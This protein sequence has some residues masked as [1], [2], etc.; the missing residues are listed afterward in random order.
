MVINKTPKQKKPNYF[1]TTE[2]AMTLWHYSA[3][4]GSKWQILIGLCLFRGLRVGE[5]VA[6]NIKD[7]KD[8]NFNEL[9][10][11][12][13]KSHII[14][15]LPIVKGFDNHL[16]DYI[17]DNLH[18]MKD[19]WLFPAHSSQSRTQHITTGMAMNKLYKMRLV[20]GKKHP[21]FL[22][23][24]KFPGS[25][26][27]N[28]EVYQRYRITFHSLRRWFETNIWDKYKDKMLLRDVM[29]YSHSKTV[30]VYINPYEVWKKEREL[31][32]TVFSDLFYDFETVA[33]GQTRLTMF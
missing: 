24:V 25:K 11:I 19:G 29:R 20:I 27:T 22:E 23:T 7:F 31:L 30:D 5:A 26:N 3:L 2:E 8:D 6:V 1:M 14:D 21:S 18:L 17:K 4:W 15:D 13:E 32:N 12:M 9:R 33:K 28:A 16:R 10:V